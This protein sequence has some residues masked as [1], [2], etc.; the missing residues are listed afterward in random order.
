MYNGG[1][2]IV[3]INVPYQWFGEIHR[4]AFVHATLQG[5]AIDANGDGW[6]YPHSLRKVIILTS[7]YGERNICKIFSIRRIP[8]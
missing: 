2:M 1:E 5:V 8:L 4:N 7:I 6:W 3:A